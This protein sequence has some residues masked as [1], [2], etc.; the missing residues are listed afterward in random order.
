MLAR[1]SHTGCCLTAAKHAAGSRR[2]SRKSAAGAAQ[3]AA[4]YQSALSYRDHGG[5]K[6]PAEHTVQVENQQPLGGGI[7]VI[8]ALTPHDSDF[9]FIYFIEFFDFLQGERY[10]RIILF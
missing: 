2:R 1:Y 7:T 8:H 5:L 3:E 4:V 10:N 6:A 9:V